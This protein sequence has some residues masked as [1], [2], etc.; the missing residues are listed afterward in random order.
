LPITIPMRQQSRSGQDHEFL[1]EAG[2]C[3]RKSTRIGQAQRKCSFVSTLA[4]RR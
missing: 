3:H 4:D 1:G 2:E